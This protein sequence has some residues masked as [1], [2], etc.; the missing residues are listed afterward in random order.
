LTD[1][2]TALLEMADDSVGA[3]EVLLGVGYPDKAVSQAYYVMFYAAGAL[4][5]EKSIRV[6]RHSAVIAAFGREF[7]RPGLLPCELHRWLQEAFEARN[8]SDY[9]IH[10]EVLPKAAK[11]HIERAE[12]FLKQVRNYL[13][14]SG[15]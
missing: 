7:A 11:T 9:E 4:L 15:A 12:R 8:E 2:Q 10:G 3:A 6:K 13:K 5:L 14:A 1:D